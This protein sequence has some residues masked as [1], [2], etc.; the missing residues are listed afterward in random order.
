[1]VD[2]KVSHFTRMRTGVWRYPARYPYLAPAPCAATVSPYGGSVSALLF[3][4]KN[5]VGT[6]FKY[7]KEVKK[8]PTQNLPVRTGDRLFDYLKTVSHS[9]VGGCFLPIHWHLEFI[10]CCAFLS[11]LSDDE[12]IH[13]PSAYP[14]VR[15]CG[16]ACA[17]AQPTGFVNLAFLRTHSEPWCRKGVGGGKLIAHSCAERG[18]LGPRGSW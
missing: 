16:R 18:A 17:T 15:K 14:P 2:V 7:Q 8:P 11:L 13:Y 1:M 5:T 3:P 9:M 12:L 6:A 4:I 10:A